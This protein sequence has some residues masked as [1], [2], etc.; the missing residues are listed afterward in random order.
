MAIDP[1][2]LQQILDHPRD[3]DP[4]LVLADSLQSKNDPRGELIIAQCRLAE[5]GTPREERATL[6]METARLL[7]AHG[8]KWMAVVKGVGNAKMARGFIDSIVANAKKLADKCS[9]IFEREPVTRLTITEANSKNLSPLA[10]GGAFARVLRLTI[11]GNIGAGGA[12]VLAGALGKRKIA[13]PLEYLNV[14]GT[15]LDADAIAALVDVLGGCRSLCLTGNGI[16]DEGVTAIAKAKSLSNLETLYLSANDLTDEGLETLA[17]AASLG[18]LAKLA[19][20]RN[21]EV[22]EESLSAIAKS[23][24]LASLRWLEY[25]DEDGMQNIAVR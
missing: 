8:D 14:G 17:S 4:R 7:Q 15:G 13:E 10:A 22:T 5:R 24:K 21:E 2:L 20:A 18:S 6:K 12:R 9:E 25:S 1:K 3:D 16:G 11:R 19:V 23:K